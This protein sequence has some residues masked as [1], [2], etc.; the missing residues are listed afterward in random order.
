MGD[1][2]SWLTY[3]DPY[4]G[5]LFG[6]CVAFNGLSRDVLSLRVTT[7]HVYDLYTILGGGGTRSLS[8]SLSVSIGVIDPR[9]DFRL[10]R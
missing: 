8:K 10:S 3:L 7:I 6:L 9:E 1:F 5:S 4:L 2:S